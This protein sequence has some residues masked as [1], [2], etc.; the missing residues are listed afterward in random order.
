MLRD[1][2]TPSSNSLL[3]AIV[4]ES[5]MVRF[6]LVVSATRCP[7]LTHSWMSRRVLSEPGVTDSHGYMRKQTF[8]AWNSRGSR[9]RKYLLRGV[10]A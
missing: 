5:R 2:F 8:M 4:V 9:A 10:F 7:R 3:K 6:A 1:G